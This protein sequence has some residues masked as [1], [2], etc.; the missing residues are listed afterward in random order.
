MIAVQGSIERDAEKG[1]AARMPTSSSCRV[2]TEITEGRRHD[3]TPRFTCEFSSPL[4]TKRLSM[5][6]SSLGG[7]PALVRT[8]VPVPE[9]QDNNSLIQL[10]LEVICI[11][12]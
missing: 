10:L 2:S 8:R 1:V 7:P 11:E 4:D 6:S 9:H 12:T 5:V 3:R